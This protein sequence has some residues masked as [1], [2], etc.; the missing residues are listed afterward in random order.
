MFFF[1]LLQ[2]TNVSENN[3]NNTSSRY[4]KMYLDWHN[5]W[6]HW[7]SCNFMWHK[8]DMSTFL[9]IHKE[10]SVLALVFACSLHILLPV[11]GATHAG[12]ARSW[13][14]FGSFSASLCWWN[15]FQIWSHVYEHVRRNNKK[16]TLFWEKRTLCVDKALESRNIFCEN[17]TVNNCFCSEQ[18]LKANSY[19]LPTKWKTL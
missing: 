13:Q 1:T 8:V 19:F 16:W 15:S 7:W 10:D 6:S 5:S 14:N 18:T 12:L 2:K 3:T 4:L 9:S 17:A 11:S